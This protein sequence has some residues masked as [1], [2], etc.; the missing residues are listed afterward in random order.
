MTLTHQAPPSFH[1]NHLLAADLSPY[2]ILN[3]DS[4]VTNLAWSPD[5]KLLASVSNDESL[6]VHDV[7]SGKRCVSVRNLRHF[8]S[9]VA[10]DPKGKYI[11]TMSTDR[12]MDLIDAVKGTRLRAF[13]V[14]ALPSVTIG[15]I[16]LE[17]KVYK[18]FHDDQ[19]MS[20]QR[21]VAFSPCGQLI[22]APCA[23]LEA[24][25]HDL[26]GTLVFRRSDLEND[27]PLAFLPCPKATFLIRCCPIIMTLKKDTT[28]Y[29]G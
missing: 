6:F 20:F 28:N 11:V 16:Q 10:W 15:D 23:N 13:G 5:G 21:G 25:T 1:W 9:G 17:H 4:E 3:H 14:C 22:I 18:L 12:K 24:G 7:T 29:T 26:Y 27:K 19:L 8:P 2:G